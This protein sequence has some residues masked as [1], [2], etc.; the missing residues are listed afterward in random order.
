MTA[1]RLGD[2]LECAGAAI[3][4]LVVTSCAGG[5]SA[6]SNKAAMEAIG[7]NF[8]AQ[9][10]CQHALT[11]P[12]TMVGGPQGGFTTANQSYLTDN[13]PVTNW[14]MAAIKAPGGSEID[15]QC[16]INWRHKKVIY[17]YAK[18]SGTV[19]EKDRE[20]LR[21]QGLC[22]G[23]AASEAVPAPKVSQ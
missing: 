6:A 10:V 2:L 1:N 7:C 8:D 20:W 5:M 18:P 19:S 15:V 23:P 21:T 11:A 13:S 12:V 3:L 14:T 9:R 22:T 16:Q 4:A 17:A